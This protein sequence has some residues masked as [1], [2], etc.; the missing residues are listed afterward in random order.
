MKN[1]V[2][3]KSFPN[4]LSIYLDEEMPFDQL[5]KEIGLKFKESA[6]FFKNASMVL[7]FEGRK[8]SDQE[9]R[10]II[11]TITANSELNV[12]CIMGKNEETNKNYIKALQKLSYH[13]QVMENAGQFYKG[14]LKDGQMLETENSIIVLG[15]VYPGAC[16]ISSKDIII[17]GGLYG[18]AYAGGN[19]EDGHFVVALEMSPEKLKIGDFKYKTSEKQSKWPIKPKVQPK[20]AYVEDGRVKLEPITK[21]LLNN[22]PI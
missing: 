6:H 3:I 17:L 1:P 14:T 10:M 7:S 12:M 11:N 18:Q 5:L 19:G 20:I 4:G 21:E 2:I 16:V 13:Q 22:L 8:L 15:D 9:E